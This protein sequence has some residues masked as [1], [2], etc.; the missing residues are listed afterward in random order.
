MASVFKRKDRNGKLRNVWEYK[1]RDEFGKYR[2]GVGFSCK[3]KTLALAR[4][5]EVNARL[6]RN[7][8]REPRATK[9]KA[10][11]S[12]AE[13]I[14]MYTDWGKSQA[15][16]LHQGWDKHHG[17]QLAK[18]L[19]MWLDELKL[20]VM[21]DIEL[22]KVEAAI[23]KMAA[24]NFAA[25]TIALKVQALKGLINWAL[26]RK[27]LREDP[28]LALSKMDLKACDPH[29]KLTDAEL[30]ALLAVAPPHRR[31]GYQTGYETGFRVNE[32]R[33]LR[34]QDLDMSGP[35]LRLLSEFSKD[36]KEWRQPIPQD[37]ADKLSEATKGMP[38]DAPLLK[39]ASSKAWKLFKKDLNAAGIAEVIEEKVGEKIIRHKA[40][41]HS[42]RKVF[43]SNLFSAKLDL[44]T[45]QTLGRLS[46][47][48][49]AVQVYAMAEA[50]NLRDGVNTVSKKISD[51]MNACCAD[52][53][54]NFGVIKNDLT[55]TLRSN[56]LQDKSGIGAMRH[57]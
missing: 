56:E 34:V 49:L 24:E 30:S 2:Y 5:L 41:W 42:F 6:I 40:T 11:T 57:H 18:N 21:A 35:S 28:L 26:T 25:K 7:G 16:R 38:G 53:T 15:G 50:P 29:R 23:V 45:I 31:L 37:L 33:S 46:S 22:E 13:V 48:E 36:R 10:G 51:G 47:T 9:Q 44:K 17:S 32:L 43:I 4:E 8:D 52:V 12:A 54:R 39:I 20:E 14:R 27:Y 19:S 3:Q 55:N 1:H